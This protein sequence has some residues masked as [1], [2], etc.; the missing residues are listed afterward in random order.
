MAQPSSVRRK[1]RGPWAWL[2]LAGLA[3]LALFALVLALLLGPRRGKA[4]F[5]SIQQP[6]TGSRLSS[7]DGGIIVLEAS[8]SSP[9]ARYLLWVDGSP[10]GFV[11]PSGPE[12]AL[13]A[14]VRFRWIPETPGPHVL[15]ATA[16]DQRGLAGRSE[17]VVVD[18]VADKEPDVVGIRVEIMPGDTTESLAART[19]LPADALSHNLSSGA[20]SPQ[21]VIVAVPRDQL[22]ASFFGEGGSEPARPE[23][24]P[25]PP[26]ELPLPAGSLP[27]DAVLT[28]ESA[29]GCQVRLAWEFDSQGSG[30]RVYRFGG[31]ARDFTSIADVERGATD[32]L[33]LL[34]FGG[35]YLYVL[36]SVTRQGEFSGPMQQIEVPTEVC[37][38]QAALPDSGPAWMQFE[39]TRLITE[40]SLDRAYCYFSLDGKRFER[41][42]SAEDSSLARLGDAWDLTPYLA[43]L[44][45]QVFQHAVQAPVS[46]R[47]DCWG[48]RGGEL[49]P[50]G[51]LTDSRPRK[52]WS[53]DLTGMGPRFQ[54]FYS[55][56]TYHNDLPLTRE[57]FYVDEP[58]PPPFRVGFAANPLDCLGHVNRT[59]GNEA[60]GDESLLWIW[61]CAVIP[62]VL[63]WEW[64]PEED[65]TLGEIAGYQVRL[66]RDFRLTD[67][68]S[69]IPLNQIDR[70][71]RNQ[72]LGESG[73]A[74]LAIPAPHPSCLRSFGYTVRAFQD[75]PDEGRRFSEPSRVFEDV[76]A[77]CSDSAVVEFT[78]LDIEVRHLDDG[79]VFFCGGESLQAYGSGE[80]LIHSAST[81]ALGNPVGDTVSHVARTDFWTPECDA[82]FGTGCVFAPR[83]VH[84]GTI[85]L[86][87]EDL[88]RCQGGACGT[89]GPGQN[90]V[91][92]I[93]GDEDSVEFSFVLWDVDGVEDDV[94]CGTMEDVGVRDR[95]RQGLGLEDIETD[96]FLVGL[97]PNSLRRWAEIDFVDTFQNV[98]VLDDQDSECT[99][100]VGIRGLGLYQGGI[101]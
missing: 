29:G 2:L 23:A 18:V 7:V 80:W 75:D 40:D 64:P 34:P 13:A 70:Q 68:E 58:P 98:G 95:L 61:G 38:N 66:D 21:Q 9:I 24:D 87:E 99:L 85:D 6:M 41:I 57:L 91:R 72:P 43:G 96:A 82:G 51:S 11:D 16:Y 44:Q 49:L 76:R 52:D 32:Y 22:P 8:G 26:S 53:S 10:Q 59:G 55:L 31:L 5:V 12:T 19:G 62:D 97:G 69:Q 48:W 63:V 37:P 54:L 101:P 71:Q 90:T 84:N 4:P 27:L 93:V 46:V 30:L 1:S 77:D 33:D 78:L 36:S 60:F 25:S 14:S 20:A 73:S 45:R 50:L 89:F 92:L 42:P 47:M 79:C 67:P 3:L 94:W 100:R 83:T 39:A 15:M 81:D 56:L 86:A 65:W 74:N 28:A 17:P 35:E 88:R